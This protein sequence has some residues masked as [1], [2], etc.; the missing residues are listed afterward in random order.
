VRAINEW[1]D[2]ID[3]ASREL[4]TS[5]RMGRLIALVLT[6]GNALNAARAPA[7]GFALSSLPKLLDTRS[8][9]GRD[10]QTMPATSSAPSTHLEPS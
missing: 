5:S 7:K 6:L 8:F 3:S 9:D 1:I 4:R 10:I 2:T